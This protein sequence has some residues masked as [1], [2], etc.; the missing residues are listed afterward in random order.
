MIK[1]RLCRCSMIKN[2]KESRDDS[3]ALKRLEPNEKET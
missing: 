3:I 2:P 1:G